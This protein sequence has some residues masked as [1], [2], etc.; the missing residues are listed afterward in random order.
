MK[1]EGK[2]KEWGYEEG[3]KR[4]N[5]G[6]KK[7]TR[8]EGWVRYVRGGAPVRQLMGQHVLASYRTNGSIPK[9]SGLYVSLLSFAG[10][11]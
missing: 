5:S 9:M 11:M 7:G 6:R 3:G 10:E 4:V 8:K 1:M 2:G